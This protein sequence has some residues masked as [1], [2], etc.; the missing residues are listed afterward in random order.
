[1]TVINERLVSG[2]YSFNVNL[3]TFASGIYFYRIQAGEFTATKKF[4]LLK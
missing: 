2:E 1:M 4:I 3:S